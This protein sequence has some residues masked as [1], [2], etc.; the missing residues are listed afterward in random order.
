VVVPMTKQTGSARKATF[1]VGQV[2]SFVE[3]KNYYE[4]RA[5]RNTSHGFYYDI[6]TLDLWA[7][8]D[9]RALTKREAGR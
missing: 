3:T 7:E 8:S 5:I 2:V 9:L 6:G 1:R 4:V